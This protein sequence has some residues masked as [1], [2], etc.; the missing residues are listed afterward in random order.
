MELFLSV[1]K[2]ATFRRRRSGVSSIDEKGTSPGQTA[3]VEQRVAAIA[4]AF[5]TRGMEPRPFIKTK[6]HVAEEEWVP[7]NGILCWR[8]GD[9]DALETAT[10]L[11]RRFL[12]DESGLAVGSQR[13]ATLHPT[14]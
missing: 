1:R 4:A 2:T 14:P 11:A 3:S 8:R 9:P 12:N 10:E 13:H 6:T 5:E 7:R